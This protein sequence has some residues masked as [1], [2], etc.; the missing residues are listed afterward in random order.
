MSAGRMSTWPTALAGSVSTDRVV[1]A[2]HESD[3]LSTS[4]PRAI[5][6][7]TT[8]RWKPGPFAA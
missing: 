6:N 5:G 7:G 2:E 4:S 3:P 8:G 1:G